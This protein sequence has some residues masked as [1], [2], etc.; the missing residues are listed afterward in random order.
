MPERRANGGLKKFVDAHRGISQTTV[1]PRGDLVVLLYTSHIS[2]ACRCD[3]RARG[4]IFRK[5]MLGRFA[6]SQRAVTS[7]RRA[8]FLPEGPFSGP[9]G[10][11]KKEV[12]Q[13]C[14]Q[15]LVA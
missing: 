13:H 2:I 10:N 9:S 4:R 15:G 3:S 12:E 14:T 8:E 5:R 11:K 7:G 6:E 1:Y